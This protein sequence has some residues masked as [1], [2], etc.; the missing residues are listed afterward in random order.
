MEET[1]YPSLDH[2]ATCTCSDIS[3]ADIV[4]GEK[5]MLQRLSYELGS[6]SPSEYIEWTQDGASV[7]RDTSLLTSYF[8][9]AA[10]M[11]HLFIGCPSSFLAAASLN[12][13][14]IVLEKGD[15]TEDLVSSYGFGTAVLTVPSFDIWASCRHALTRHPAVYKKYSSKTFDAVAIKVQGIVQQEKVN[16]PV[17]LL[18]TQNLERQAFWA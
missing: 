13:S 8:V 4:Q 16:T 14:L 3:E 9:E 18:P 2:F 10:I 17:D 11:N 1:V 12:L 5:I 7:D 15:W 6:P